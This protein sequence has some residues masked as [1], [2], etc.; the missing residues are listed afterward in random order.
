MKYFVTIGDAT[1]EVEVEDGRVLVDGATLDAELAALPG[2]PLYHL[3]LGGAAWTVAAQP[4][5]GPGRWILGIA[6]ERAEIRVHDERSRPSG[7]ASG[8]GGAARG[9]VVRAPMPG[10][11]VRVEVAAGQRVDPGAGLV[12]VEA[13]KMENEL[14]APHAGTVETVHV[15][16]GQTVEKGMPLVTLAQTEGAA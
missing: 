3:L 16:A 11:V 2:S 4:L 13:M 8:A 15:A 1:I 5:D 14:R 6:G 12:V 10:L 9:G 7:S